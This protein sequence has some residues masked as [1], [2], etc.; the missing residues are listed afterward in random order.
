MYTGLEI[1]AKDDFECK[2]HTQVMKII[3]NFLF[4]KQNIQMKSNLSSHVEFAALEA[5]LTFPTCHNAIWQNQLI[6]QD[7][8]FYYCNE[9][10]TLQ[11]LIRI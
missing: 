2:R 11:Q 6:V 10:N 3:Q 9:H 1:F 8:H 5:H 7:T 4:I